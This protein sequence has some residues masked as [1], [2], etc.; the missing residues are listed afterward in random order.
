MDSLLNDYV[1]YYEARMKRRE[2][3]KVYLHSYPSE[4]A[5]YELVASCKDME[6][7]QARGAEIRTLALQNSIALVKDQEIYRKRIYE[8]CGEFIRA[9]APANIL[10]QADDMQTDMEL[11][12]MVSRVHQ[13]NSIDITVDQL[14]GIFYSDFVAMENIEV[15]QQATIPEEWKKDCEAY[16]QETMNRGKKL[17]EETELPE[18]RHWQPGWTLNY[19]LLQEDRHRRLIPVN[20]AELEKKILLHKKYKPA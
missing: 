1:L 11:V 3:T 9:G 10:A 7:L 15:Y 5:I 4:K 19:A 20:D 2:N 8:D 6:A 13:K 17:W 16:A 18:A 12:E 14:T